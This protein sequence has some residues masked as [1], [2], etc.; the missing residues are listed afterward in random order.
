MVETTVL[1]NSLLKGVMTTAL[2]D[3]PFLSSNVDLDTVMTAGVY[4]VDVS[5]SGSIAN[6]PNNASQGVLI[7]FL[8]AI[9]TLVQ[10]FLPLGTAP[11]PAWRINW[12]QTGW[13]AW[14]AFA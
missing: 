8:T 12:Y 2:V 7:V 10:V 5:S 4:R 11:T 14:R 1:T 13:R 9:S 3:R 6:S